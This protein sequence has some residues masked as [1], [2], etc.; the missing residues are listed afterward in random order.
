M[1]NRLTKRRKSHMF[2]IGLIIFT[3]F[4]AGCGKNE[5][6]NDASN[7]ESAKKVTDAMGHKVAVPANPK[8]IIAPYL[9]DPLIVLGEKPV[10]QWSVANGIQDYL[11][12]DLKNVPK[13]DYNL[14]PEEVMSYNPDLIIIGSEGMVQKG[15]Y[16]K[17]SKIAPTYVLGDKTAND[18]RK[19]LLKIGELLNK[20]DKAEK[21]LGDY[22]KK[23]AD[24]KKRIQQAIGNPSVAV[25]WLTQKQ[26]YIVDQSRSSGA[27]LYHD[28]GLTVPSMVQELPS[29]SNASWNPISLEKLADLDADHIFLVNSDKGQG[30]TVL[31]NPVWK[32]LPAVKAGHVYEMSQKSS[33]LYNGLIANEQIIDDVEKALVK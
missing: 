31:N 26:F 18:W 29:S 32:N 14:P 16:D 23:A 3:I 24:T 11:Q 25:L 33:W 2:F 20:S 8:R 27:V 12:P 10:A 13:I 9:E 19:T 28:L 4:L 1:F 7:S 5:A 21:A 30:E 6:S 17:Y 15:L 22:D